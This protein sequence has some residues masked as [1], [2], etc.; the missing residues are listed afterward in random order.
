MKKMIEVILVCVA[1]LFIL[2]IR[3]RYWMNWND[4]SRLQG[5]HAF[6]GASKYHWINYDA[7]RIAES[8]VNYQAKERGTR[9]HAYA[10][11]SIAL[12]QKLPRSKKTLNSYVND[13]IGFCMTPEVVLY[14]SENCYGTADTIHFANN[15]L[16]I[17]DLKTGLVPA[18]ME[19]LFIYDA[20]FCL[21]YGVKPRDIQIE[22]RIYQNDDIWIVN[23]TCEDIDPIISK[24]I[25]FNKIITELKLG[26]AA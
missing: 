20:L 3:R 26:A 8:F 22:N 18:H 11:E 5:Q 16:R 19:Q 14:Y 7:A 1:I 21:E 23:P 4:H 12:G 6:L 24:I 15:F 10:A 25:E 17:H 9:L 13:A 2:R